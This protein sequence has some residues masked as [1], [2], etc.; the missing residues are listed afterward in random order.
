MDG[1][2]LTKTLRVL[3]KHVINGKTY[4][5]GGYRMG[6]MQNV[7]ENCGKKPNIERGQQP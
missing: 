2:V 5:R 6:Q 3:G 1:S 4:V 7:A